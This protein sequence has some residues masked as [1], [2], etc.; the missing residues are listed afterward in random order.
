MKYFYCLLLFVFTSPFF[1]RAQTNYK[2]GY[3][4]NLKGDTIRGFIDYRDWNNNPEKIS[5]KNTIESKSQI[6]NTN[7]INY[8]AVDQVTAYQKFVVII[9]TKADNL[10][11]SSSNTDTSYK[12]KVFLQ[13]LQKGENLALY[14]YA[15]PLKTLFYIG[16]A[17]DFMPVELVYRNPD[18]N[19]PAIL[20]QNITGN[21]ITY[22][23]Q[24]F[25]LSTKYHK[26]SEVVKKDI[27]MSTY[28]TSDLT[29]LVKILNGYDKRTDSIHKKLYREV[30]FF[31]G[32]GISITNTSSNTS[33]PYNQSGGK[34]HT[35]LFP[36]LTL[37]FNAYTNPIT[38]RLILAGELGFTGNLF[39]VTYQNLKF[40][41]GTFQ[42]KFNQYTISFSPQIIYNIYNG[43]SFRF[44]AGGGGSVNFSNYGNRLFT[45]L[46]GTNNLTVQPFQFN[47]FSVSFLAKAGVLLYNKVE[48]YTDNLFNTDVTN[49]NDNYFFLQAKV[50]QIGINYHF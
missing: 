4:I 19:R 35:S 31:A 7:T 46:T 9:S 13:V 29:N 5:F 23:K 36:K 42:Y 25:N 21:E 30:I 39:N 47:N 27:E 6:F 34:N 44:F 8:F 28:N 41:Y 12:V 26:D 43:Q 14:S 10:N 49:Q 38:R 1:C 32:T 2:P 40:P 33:T 24:L 18:T 17:P 37:G 11:N 20:T 3:I 45:S 15:S 16:E 50:I 22:M 48:I